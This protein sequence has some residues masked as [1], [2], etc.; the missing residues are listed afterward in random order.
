MDKVISA[1]NDIGVRVDTMRTDVLRYVRSGDDLVIKLKT[2]DQITVSEF[3]TPAENGSFHSLIFADGTEAEF[4]QGAEGS[5]GMAGALGGAGIAALAG[6]G[7]LGAAALANDD[8]D[9][10]VDPTDGTD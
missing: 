7:V 1:G 6:L 3:Y 2:G 8:G 5:A 9:N 10:D 4:E